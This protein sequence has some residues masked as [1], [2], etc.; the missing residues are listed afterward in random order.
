MNNCVCIQSLTQKQKA[1]DVSICRHK[2]IE[3]EIH[4]RELTRAI[5]EV[6]KVKICRVS[7][8]TGNPEKH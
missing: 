4:F 8:Q 7:W 3:R 5:V 1:I 6:V 2:S